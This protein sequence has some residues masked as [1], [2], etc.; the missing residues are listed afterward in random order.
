MSPAG[1]DHSHFRVSEVMDGSL[2]QIP[3][4]NKI[5][6]QNTNEF[7]FGSLE[8]YRQGA[9]F[10]TSAIDTMDALNNK[11]SLL[12]FPRARG[13]DLAGFVGCIVQNLDLEELPWIFQFAHGTKQTL[14][15]VHF[16]KDRKLNR[17]LWQFFNMTCLRS[18]E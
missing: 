15:D 9:G 6:V 12:Q 16:V 17:H 10:E 5:G 18:E 13:D 3:L 7:T 8:P 4:G 14:G 1:L 2:Q 11:A